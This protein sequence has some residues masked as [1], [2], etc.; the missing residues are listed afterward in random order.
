M[1]KLFTA[2]LV[3]EQVQKGK[4]SLDDTLVRCVAL[5]YTRRVT[6]RMLL[7]QTSGIPDYTADPWFD[8][9]LRDP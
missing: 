2:T 1:T 4:V 6:V 8:A 3:M 9:L 5:L 7:N